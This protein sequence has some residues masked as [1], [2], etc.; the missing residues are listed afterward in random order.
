MDYSHPPTPKTKINVVICN[1]ILFVRSYY[2]YIGATKACHLGSVGV[3]QLSPRANQEWMKKLEVG[4]INRIK[5]DWSR[6]WPNHS[7]Q[8]LVDI[9]VVDAVLILFTKGEWAAVY[10]IYIFSV[11]KPDIWL[12]LSETSDKH[13]DYKLNKFYMR[14]LEMK[15]SRFG[16]LT[17]QYWHLLWMFSIK[18]KKHGKR[19]S[20]LRTEIDVGSN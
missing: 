4:Y 18:K 2:W 9:L 20:K 19:L 5:L 6:R 15:N 11:S 10:Y 14:Y 7:K 16:D 12:L 8:A 17:N 3:L 1:L 13:I